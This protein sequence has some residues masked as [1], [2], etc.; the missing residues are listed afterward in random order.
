MPSHVI[1]G[2]GRELGIILNKFWSPQLLIWFRHL[3]LNQTHRAC[4]LSNRTMNTR[5][6]NRTQSNDVSAL[7]QS[8]LHQMDNEANHSTGGK[9]PGSTGQENV[10]LLWLEYDENSVAYTL[11]KSEISGDQVRICI[12]DSMHFLINRRKRRDSIIAFS[13]PLL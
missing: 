12:S 8:S 6:W 10:F 5:L 2:H 1:W 7:P 13:S 3:P 4:G 11:K 9:N